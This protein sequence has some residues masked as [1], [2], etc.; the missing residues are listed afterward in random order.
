VHEIRNCV[1]HQQKDIPFE[2]IVAMIDDA[3]FLT[4]VL[5]DEKRSTILKNAQEKLVALYP[6]LEIYHKLQTEGKV[7]SKSECLEG[8]V[9]DS[10]MSIF[11]APTESAGPNEKKGVKED[12][13]DVPKVVSLQSQISSQ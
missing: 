10:V 8:E 6:V 9:I 13:S 3:L 7:E 11:D 1:L 5:R 2:V 12:T 4:T